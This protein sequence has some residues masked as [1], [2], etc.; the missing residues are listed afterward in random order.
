MVLNEYK[1]MNELI[2]ENIRLQ[3]DII[4]YKIQIN[5]MKELIR[6]LRK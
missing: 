1:S 2:E 6:K 3:S 4:G 5:D